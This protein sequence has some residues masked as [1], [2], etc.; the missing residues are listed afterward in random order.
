MARRCEETGASL[1]QGM[2]QLI[3]RIESMPG[4]GAAHSAL[5]TQSMHLHDGLTTIL[6]ALDELAGKIDAG[7]AH[8]GNRDSDDAADI[9]KAAQ[10]ASQGQGGAYNILHPTG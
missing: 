4:A 10:M 2:S 6:R 9:N 5:Q 3:Q 7:A 1:A 8:F